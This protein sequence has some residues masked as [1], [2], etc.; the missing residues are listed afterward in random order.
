[1]PETPNSLLDQGTRA[2]RELAV[3]QGQAYRTYGEALQRF[4]ENQIGWTEL[5]KTSGDVYFKEVAQ[6]IWSL[7]R[8]NTNVY[9]WLLS[10]AGAK[11]VRVEAEP[12]HDEP[13]AVRRTQRGRA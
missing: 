13:P 11:P 9:A 5:F 3:Q 6:A 8:A 7:V 12:P 2:L 10:A 1:M 4:G